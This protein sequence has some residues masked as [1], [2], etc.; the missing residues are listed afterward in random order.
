NYWADPT[1]QR[2]QA[3]KD[4]RSR[5]TCRSSCRRFAVSRPKLRPLLPRAYLD[6]SPKCPES[7]DTEPRPVC[8]SIVAAAE[9]DYGGSVQELSWLASRQRLSSDTLLVKRL[10]RTHLDL[11]H[12]PG[13]F[14]GAY[15]DVLPYLNDSFARLL[16]T[17]SQSVPPI[18]REDMR[19]IVAQLCEPDPVYRGHP[20]N[21]Q[22]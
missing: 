1:G 22:G 3:T 17:F 5:H 9:N 18:V 16:E 21:R 13:L 19:Q 10:L 15:A 14:V 20:L 7:D 8:V 6:Q 4:H 11:A 12:R 2:P